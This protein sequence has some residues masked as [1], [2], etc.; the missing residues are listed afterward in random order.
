M[1]TTELKS[2]FLRLYQIALA[3][4]EFANME[5]HM[6]HKF[7]EDK[8]IDKDDLLHMLTAPTDFSV[9]IPETLEKKVE[10]L[11][12]FARM[13]WADHQ[14]TDDEYSILK[15]YCRK[16]GFL[17]ENVV[18]LADYLIDCAKKELPKEQILAHLNE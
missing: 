18:P 12:D 9:H 7:A 13:I 8:G 10:Y 1:L 6:L 3:D 16:F 14:I 11:Y 17:E 2:H 4:D 15:K 5:L